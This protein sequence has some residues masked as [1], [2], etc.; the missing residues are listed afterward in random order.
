MSKFSWKFSI[1]PGVVGT[2][3]ALCLVSTAALAQDKSAAD[4]LLSGE[5]VGVQPVLIVSNSPDAAWKA[6]G[7]SF[8]SG[9]LKE[10][11]VAALRGHS[12]F[13]AANHRVESSQKAETRG[14]ARA[15]GDGHTAHGFAGTSTKDDISALRYAWVTGLMVTSIQTKGSKTKEMLKVLKAKKNV[16]SGLSDGVRKGIAD[17]LKAAE[18]GHVE[19]SAIARII[20]SA[21]NGLGVGPVRA[22]GYFLAGL[23]S[24]LSVLAASQTTPN[25]AFMSM[26]EPIAIL[27]E[28]DAR[29]GGTDHKV[30]KVMRDIAASIKTG[31][32]SARDI[33]KKSAQLFKLA[34]D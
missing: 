16:I 5:C 8:Q 28:K 12:V 33:A 19:G 11:D 7:T 10:K 25:S 6:F 26:A 32:S 21:Q 29:F 20:R 27:L 31:K 23:W 30:A 14:I 17:L 9:D 2:A 1:K 22:H 13:N 4:E 3:I 34:S 18:N 24:G 15:V